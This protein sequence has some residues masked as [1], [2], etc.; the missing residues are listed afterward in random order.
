[1]P[2][3]LHDRLAAGPIL[4]DGAM[5]TMLYAAG[6]GLDDCFDALNLSRPETVGAVHRAYLDAGAC[7]I[8]TN[9]F[10]ANR[11]KLAPFGL[12]GEVRRINKAGVRL[13]RE[14]REVAGSAALVAGSVGPSGRTL[15]PF[16][17]AA[18]DAV[19]AIFREQIEALLEGG[20]DL[21]LLETFGG[22]EEVAEAI[23]AAKDACDL[24]LVASLT[25]ADDG[26]TIAGQSPEDVVAAVAPLGPA[27]LGAN[28]SVG[29]RRL[30]PVARAMAAALAER[31]GAET[32][33]RPALACMP[34]AGWPAQ[35]AGRVIYP[36]SPEYFAAF[37]ADAVRCG[38][39]VVGGCCGTTPAHTAAMADALAAASRAPTLE[40]AR[41]VEPARRPARAAGPE[42]DAAPAEGP[43]G[44]ARKLAGGK[45]VVAVEIDP[46]KGLNPAKAIEGARL[47]QEAGVDAIN[48]ADSPMARVRMSALTISHLIQDKVGVETILHL[49]TRD[50]SLM[51]LQSE[52]LGAH[53]VGVRNILALTGD[54]PSLGDY[55]DSSAVYD[56][57]SVGLV[58]VLARLNAGTDS[59]G[60]AIGRAASFSIACAVDPTR[61]DV[62]HEAERLKAKLAAGAQFVMTQPIYDPAVW[63][64]FLDV[65][66]APALPVPVVIGILPLQSSKHAEFL[67]NEVPGITLSD[68]ARERMRRAGPDG[69][70][71]GIRMAQDLLLQ[72]RPH[73]Q[74]VYLMPSFGRYEVAAEVL[75]VLD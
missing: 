3:P 54:P 10:G 4:A 30:L 71:E 51:G 11:A 42:L 12:D 58:R 50:R 35:V 62:A 53:A 18:P 40:A 22:I 20:V 70:A 6:A 27:V 60:A 17:T 28:C 52:L 66:G 31:D 44:L 43:T 59:A 26:R 39:T 41:P 24:P 47:L 48:V 67:H 73:A 1:M 2:H 36:S 16:G 63:A 75:R 8:K 64:R 46:P 5:G 61:A 15:A 23:G 19:R 32:A 57:D 74:G 14:A 33:L 29:P 69:R 55:P 72:L 56:V 34:N 25:F 21:L 45:F 65:Y 7:L 9:T 38:V 37:A 49:T 13:A 68:E